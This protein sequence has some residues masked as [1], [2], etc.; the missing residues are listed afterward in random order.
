[1]ATSPES[2][3]PQELTGA[4]LHPAWYSPLV[5]SGLLPDLL[6]RWGIRR[7]CAARLRD[8]AA[9][10]IDVQQE[11]RRLLLAQLDAGPIAVCTDA[12]NAQHYELPAEFFQHVLGRH[13]K[14]SCG[15]WPPGV[16][17]LDESEEAMLSLTA[18]RVRIAGGQRILELGCG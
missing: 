8:E 13:M 12:A 18:A 15:Y 11:R 16:R 14:Y 10:G 5:E 17:T 6:L 9:G 1:M 4:S 2:A 7:I 3:A